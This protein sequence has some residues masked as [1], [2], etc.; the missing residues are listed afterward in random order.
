MFLIYYMWENSS[1]AYPIQ[2]IQVNFVIISGFSDPVLIA[3]MSIRATS[4]KL[5]PCLFIIRKYG[6]FLS[7]LFIWNPS[8]YTASHDYETVLS[9]DIFWNWLPSHSHSGNIFLAYEALL[10]ECGWIITKQSAFTKVQL[11]DPCV[12]DSSP[13][14]RMLTPWDHKEA[15]TS[16]SCLGFFSRS[17][18]WKQ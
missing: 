4:I 5:F 14:A 9:L 16:S 8:F 13:S 1:P 17:Q 3:K 7:Y 18:G 11:N 10:V 2:V 12:L 15:K 6:L